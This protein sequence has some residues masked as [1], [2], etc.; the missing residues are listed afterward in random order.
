MIDICSKVRQAKDFL[1]MSE[2]AKNDFAGQVIISGYGNL[3]T[4]KVIGFSEEK[5]PESFTSKL[6]KGKKLTYIEYYFEKYGLVVKDKKQP[7][8][9]VSGG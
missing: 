3:K 8:L 6:I 7:M 9:R 2:K 5:T 1:E 4:Y